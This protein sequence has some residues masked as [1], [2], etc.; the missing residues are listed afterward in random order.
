MAAERQNL[1]ATALAIAATFFFALAISIRFIKGYFMNHKRK[2]SCYL[3]AEIKPQYAFKRVLADNSFSQFKHLKL[4]TTDSHSDGS[5]I[6][7]VC[8]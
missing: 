1:I 4:H 6:Q 3:N 7:T 2:K 5:Y 8:V